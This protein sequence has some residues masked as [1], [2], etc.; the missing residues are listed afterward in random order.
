MAS[1]T[2]RSIGEFSRILRE[3]HACPTPGLA[4]A[5][6]EGS[7]SDNPPFGA[8]V[9]LGVVLRAR[10]RM[11]PR[12]CALPRPPRLGAKRHPF[13]RPAPPPGTPGDGT[14]CRRSNTLGAKADAGGL[15]G[16]GDSSSG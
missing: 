12:A 7:I 9:G 6:G 10:Y 5:G 14:Q 2:A 15:A 8:L 11:K 13:P 16:A 3:T 4:L 1:R